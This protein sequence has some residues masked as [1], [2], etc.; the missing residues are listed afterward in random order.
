M[1]ANKNTLSKNIMKISI[2]VIPIILIFSSVLFYSGDKEET[3]Q[4]PVSVISK[5]TIKPNQYDMDIFSPV[6]KYNDVAKDYLNL[7]FD[8]VVVDSHN[9]FPYQVFKRGADLGIRNKNT[10]S[11]IPKFYEGG[12]DIQFLAIWIPE[13]EINSSYQYVI[14]QLNR[15]REFEKEYP[16]KFE[17]ASKYDDIKRIVLAN[18]LCG[19]PAIEGGTAVNEIEDIQTF[20][21]LGIRYIGLTWNNSNKIG[22]SAADESRKKIKGGLTDFGVQV[23]E[24]MNEV[25]MLIDVSHIGEKSFWDVIEYSK[26]PII[27]SHSCCT[28][29]NSHYRNLTDEQI[30]AIANSGGVVMINFHN[31]FTKGKIKTKSLYDL[32][33]DELNSLTELYHDNPVTLYMEKQKLLNGETVRGGVSADVV[34]DHIDYVKNL[35]GIDYVGIGSDMDGGISVPYDLYDVTC[36]PVLTQKMMERGYTEPEIRKVLGLNFLRVF[37]QVCG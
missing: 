37:K 11:D 4:A 1:K 21:D 27:A 23:V 14:N 6:T 32:H 20:F 2:I 25:G 5:D 36:Y 34:I 8:A 29:L 22:T 33:Q 15:L 18:K 28:A 9:D 19:I 17:I 16:D 26:S 3:E 31:D 35:V 7:H 30:K 12:I 10:Q 13:E 24:K